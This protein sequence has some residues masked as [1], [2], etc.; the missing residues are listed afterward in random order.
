MH[1]ELRRTFASNSVV[2][3]KVEAKENSDMEVVWP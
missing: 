2:S 1:E 3:R